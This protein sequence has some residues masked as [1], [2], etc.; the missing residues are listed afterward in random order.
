MASFSHPLSPSESSYWTTTNNIIPLPPYKN[1]C[2][3]FDLPAPHSLLLMRYN[4]WALCARSYYLAQEVSAMTGSISGTLSRQSGREENFPVFQLHCTLGRKQGGRKVDAPSSQSL[5][6][7]VC[8]KV[9]QCGFQ[10]I[11]LSLKP[12]LYRAGCSITKSRHSVAM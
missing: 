3:Q 9:V 5:Q 1:P 11:L 2:Q 10:T 4:I 8:Q 6:P 12:C 7:P